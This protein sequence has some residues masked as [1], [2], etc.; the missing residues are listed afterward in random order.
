[1]WMTWKASRLIK[2]KQKLYAKYKN[3]EHPAYKSAAKEAK[4]ELRR[5]RRKFEKQLAENIKSDAKSFYAYVGSKRK[6]SLKIG[7]LKDDNGNVTS[8]E[9]DMA[10][11][12]NKF[13]KTVFTK[14]NLRTVPEIQQMFCQ[15]GQLLDIHVDDSV[16]MKRL[17]KLKQD[18]APGADD[19]QPRYL[20]EI[21]EE[22]CHALTIILRKS[23]DQG[24]IPEDWR[25]ANVSPIFKKGSRG[26]ASNYRPVSLTSQVCKIYESI[27]RDA[28]V[29][30]LI[31]VNTRV[32]TP[33]TLR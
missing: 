4:R 19:I 24:V 12:L 15:Y 27:L 14:E 2:R 22:I 16:V 23:L 28:I 32:A 18:K 3:A 17:E 10:H 33:C 5:S 21:A 31:S 13:F 20:K 8:T 9:Q 11:E 7:P 30:H 25:I 6:V 1:M 29:E 26:K